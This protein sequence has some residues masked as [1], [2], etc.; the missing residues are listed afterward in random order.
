MVGLSAGWLVDM[1]VET[2]ETLTVALLAAVSVYD[3]VAKWVV[4]MVGSM[5]DK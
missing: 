4:W 3:L 5:A 1:K 2:K